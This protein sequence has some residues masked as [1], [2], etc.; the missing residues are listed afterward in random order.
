VVVDV[1]KRQTARHSTLITYTRHEH[2]LLNYL[3]THDRITVKELCKLLNISRW[4][5]QK[6]LVNLL[7]VGVIRSH[8]TE[9][10]EFYT[11]S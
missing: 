6:I 10:A 5:A 7:S 2:S 3:Q 4:R 1:L 9:K 8:T 11:S